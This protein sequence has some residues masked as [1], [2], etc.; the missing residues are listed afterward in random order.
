[1]SLYCKRCRSTNY[2][3]SGKMNGKQRYRCKDC[4]FYF[5]EGDG[6]VKYSDNDRLLS[7]TLYR[8]GLSFRSI[9][10]LVGTNNVTVLNWIRN[11]GRHIKQLVLSQP[12]EESDALDV[13]EIDE[14]WHYVQKNNA[15]YGYGLL[16]LVP[17]NESLPLKQVL[18]AANLSR[19]CGR[20]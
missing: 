8:K 15:N 14:M 5:T 17:K 18:V 4:D 1:M 20:E 7:I 10:D 13:I 3:K 11:I 12:I 9:A 2:H 19:E 16:T 6:R